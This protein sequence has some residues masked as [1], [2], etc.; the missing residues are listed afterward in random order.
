VSAPVSVPYLLPAPVVTRVSPARIPVAGGTPITVTVA[1]GTGPAPEVH[2][3]L[4][5]GSPVPV[6]VTGRTDTTITF[7]APPAPDG[8]SQDRHVVVTN[9]GGP[10][11]AVPTDVLGYRTPLSA[12][13]STPIVSAAGGV[14]RLTGDGF[15]TSASA[16]A[17]AHITATVNGA[18]APLTWVSSTAL[19]LWLPAG[20][21]GTVPA[22]VLLHDSVRGPAVTGTR[23]VAV[24]TASSVPAGS[25]SG[26][27]TTVKGVGIG[28]AH[29]WALLN[30]RGQTVRTLPVVTTWAALGSARY[31]AV[32]ITS[33]TGATVKLPAQ[34]AG[35]YRLVFA[36]DQR[37][38]P[39]AS[40]AATLAALLTFR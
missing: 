34:A 18:P 20:K 5:G 29:G 14:V 38:Y 13:V 17:A 15:T 3:V 25:R 40:L 10:S 33:T 36:P 8:R 16:F 32:L 30:S 19:N 27:T 26:W 24:I 4:D 22:I 2:L 31:G 1:N 28:A 11:A 21:P 12:V 39:G 7:T 35:T 9:D 37:S 6:T 23:Y